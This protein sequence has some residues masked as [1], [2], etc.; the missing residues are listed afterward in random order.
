MSLQSKGGRSMQIKNYT[1]IQH[2][3]KDL[4]QVLLAF[5]RQNNQSLLGFTDDFREG[6]SK[7][8]EWVG[9]PH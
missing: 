7:N 2:V 3:N 6:D 1:A 8:D 5:E 4:N 9:A